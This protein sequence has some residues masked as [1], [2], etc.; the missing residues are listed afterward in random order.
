M[1]KTASNNYPEVNQLI[2]RHKGLVESFQNF[3]MPDFD[4]KKPSNVLAPLAEADDYTKT[5][6]A[7]MCDNFVRKTMADL[8]ETSRANI[9]RWIKNSLAMITYSIAEDLTGLVISEQPLPSRSGR[10]HYLDIQ[11]EKSKGAL[12]VGTRVFD[13]LRGFIGT[14]DFSSHRVNNEPLGASGGTQYLGTAAYTTVIPGSVEITDGNLKIYDDRNGNLIGDVGSPTGSY[15]NTINYV[16]GAMGLVTSGTTTGPLKIS[17]GYNVEMALELPK[18]GIALRS[19]TVEAQP[20]ALMAEWSIQSTMDLS[21]DWGIDAEPTILDAGSKIINAER[22]KHVVNHLRRVASGGSFVFDNATPTGIT[23]RDHLD[24]FGILL[25]RT[26]HE[27]WKN[28]QR[29]RPNVLVHSPDTWFLLQYTRGFQSEGAPMKS[30]SM[31]GPV[32][33]G[34]LSM[35]NITCIAD[36]TFPDASGMLTYKGDG[37]VNTAAVLATYIPFYRSPVHQKGLRKDVAM[38]T[39]YTIHEVNSQ[40]MGTYTAINL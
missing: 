27:I 35:H 38:L 18:Y 29:V 26:Q 8:T 11:T 40:M 15:T 3:S 37:I 24:S 32:K 31:A 30:D 28:T 19:V 4:W 2:N 17:Y 5:Y 13:A 1:L 12:P 7:I 14:D 25:A 20:R 16:T 6:A 22:F 10:I 39:E 23:Y 34:T 9:P 36:P 33:S 21:A